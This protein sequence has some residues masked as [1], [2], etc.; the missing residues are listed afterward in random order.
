MSVSVGIGADVGRTVMR[1]VAVGSVGGMI[2]QTCAHVDS[3]E[4]SVPRE[5]VESGLWRSSRM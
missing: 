2:C 1:R 3:E 5:T 4:R